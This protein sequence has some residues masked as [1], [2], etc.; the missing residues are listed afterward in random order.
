MPSCRCA[1]ILLCLAAIPLDSQTAAPDVGRTAPTPTIQA[2]VRVVVLEVVVTD[3]KGEPVAG[4]NKGDFAIFEEG[5]PQTIA[6]FEEHKGA[7]LTQ[8][9]LPP[10]P[11]GVYTNFPLTQSADSVNV[12]LL[13]ALN[14]PLKDQPYVHVQ[15]LKYLEK[16]PPG[17]RVAIFTL[18]SRLRM[19]Q[20][21]TTDSTELVAVLKDKKGAAGPHASPLLASD[22]ETEANQHHIDFLI[23]ENA[24]PAGPQ[25]LAQAAVDPVNSMKQFLADTA[26][27][28][29]ESRIK[30]TLEALQQ[31]ARCLVDVPGRKNVIWFSGS[32]PTGILPDPDLPDSSATVMAFEAEIRRTTDMLASSQI[33]IYPIAAE[34]LAGDA[35]YQTDAGEIGQKR[36]SMAQRD[37]IKRMRTGAADRDSSHGA[38]EEL[39]KDTGGQ[40]FYNTNGLN[41]A[42]ARVVNNGTRYYTLTYT[43]TNKTM[44]GKFRRIRVDLAND[45]NKDKLAYRRGYFATDLTTAQTAGQSAEFDPLLPLMGRNLPDLAQIIYKI[46]VLPLNP[47]PAPNAAPAG[48]NPDLKGPVTR[49]GVDFAVAVQDLK[50]DAAPDGGRRG[51]VEVMVVAYDRD[52]K[53]LN[54][55]V[56]KGELALP[57][58]VYAEVLKAGLQIHKEIDVPK[59][60][61]YLRTGIFDMASDAAGT[62]GVPLREAATAQATGAK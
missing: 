54:S 62:L 4:L 12:L 38:M 25:N 56:T 24:S 29:T 15:M 55:V 3:G 59:Q 16:I 41:D 48:G 21:V 27:F 9:K 17:T 10:M 42:L 8:M 35:V 2:K 52:G 5:K 19:L 49:Y 20:G 34:G 18:A 53:P 40:A 11:P 6:T 39:A 45:D 44:D 7:A 47:Q 30:L 43:P 61:V 32:F 14:T 1:L 13:D 60:D 57:P 33:A 58:K 23:T 50:L 26:A 31:L 37:T 28:E 51:N 46:R 22:A 36:P